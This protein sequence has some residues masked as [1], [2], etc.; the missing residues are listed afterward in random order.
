MQSQML[1]L[2]R[3]DLE[4]YKS[5]IL[6]PRIYPKPGL[7]KPSKMLSRQLHGCFPIPDCF[8]RQ[9]ALGSKSCQEL[10]T[11]LGENDKDDREFEPIWRINWRIKATVMWQQLR[12]FIVL[13]VELLPWFQHMSKQR[14]VWHSNYQ[15]SD[16]KVREWP[17]RINS[18]EK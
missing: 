8:R 16:R 14:K 1:S 10:I 17:I 3:R 15:S 4:F 12:G 18:Q 2:P 9:I 13:T 7:P 6:L 11:E 5:W